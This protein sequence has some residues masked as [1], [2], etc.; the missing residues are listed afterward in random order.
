MFMDRVYLLHQKKVNLY[1]TLVHAIN[2]RSGK[3]ELFAGPIV[4]GETLEDAQRYCQTNNL[5][6]CIVDRLFSKIDN[7]VNVNLN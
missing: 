3:L 7:I 2:P 6:Y 5:Q 1:T 4:P